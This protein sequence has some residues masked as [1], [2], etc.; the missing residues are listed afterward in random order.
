MELYRKVRLACRVGMSDR[1]A[2][3]PWTAPL[4]DET[5]PSVSIPSA[6]TA[7]SHNVGSRGS[8]P[9]EDILRQST[10]GLPLPPAKIAHYSPPA[11]ALTSPPNRGRS[12]CHSSPPRGQASRE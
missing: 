12:S 2:A 4:A 1:A 5:L 8:G 9:L 7:M 11:K 6:R 3:T 10:T